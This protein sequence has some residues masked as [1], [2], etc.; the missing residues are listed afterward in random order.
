MQIHPVNRLKNQTTEIMKTTIRVGVALLLTAATCHAEPTS[1]LTVAVMDFRADAAA[2]AYGKSVTPLVIANLSME[3][4]LVLVERAELTKAL[5]EKAFGVSGMVN[6]DTA[7]QIGQI[8]GAK[9][10]VSGQVMKIGDN[11]LVIVAST[12][13]TDNGRLFAD[14]VE[15]SPDK[16]MDL[17]SE[18]SRKIA[19]TIRSQTTNLVSVA[20]ESSADRIGRIV[21]NIAGTNRPSVSVKINWPQGPS[22]PVIPANT[23]FG[24]ILMKA[25]FAV[26]DDR[27]ERKPDIEITGLNDGGSG[28]MKGGLFTWQNVMELQVRDRRSGNLITLEHQVD[29]ASEISLKGAQ[30]AAIINAIDSLAERVLPL[31]A[32]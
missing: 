4:N 18:L 2:A 1:Q 10:F 6:S 3:T 25:G 5:G 15:G 8:T 9:V 28:P 26:A 13:G 29:S 11:H 21:H 17:T 20:R 7:A 19:Q 23:E 22:R 16:L 30:R 32:K 31:L 27:S 12:I 24:L 14:K